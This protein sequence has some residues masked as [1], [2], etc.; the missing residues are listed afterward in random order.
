MTNK[1]NRTHMPFGNAFAVADEEVMKF[2]TQDA[3]PSISLLDENIHTKFLSEYQAWIMQTTNNRVLG[4]DEYKYACYT[5]GTTEA[6]DKFYAKHS[7]KRFRFFEGE[8]LYHRLSCRN[9]NY[10]WDYIEDAD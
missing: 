5:N 1:Y 8:Y 4:L 6:F 7:T 9:N 2:Y 3:N 10:D